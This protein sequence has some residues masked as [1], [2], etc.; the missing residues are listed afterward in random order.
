MQ[1]DRLTKVRFAVA[2]DPTKRFLRFQDS[3]PRHFSVMEHFPKKLSFQNTR[4]KNFFITSLGIVL[5][6]GAL[7]LSSVRH[8]LIDT[9]APLTQLSAQ[10][11]K[12]LD[13]F[14]KW[15]TSTRTHLK[16]IEQLKAQNTY[17]IEKIYALKATPLQNTFLNQETAI[18]E[19]FN[20]LHLPIKWHL[21]DGI[22]YALH[23]SKDYEHKHQLIGN[24]ASS[25]KGVLGTIIEKD[26]G[27]LSIRPLDHPQSRLA[28]M[29]ENEKNH[30]VFA[31][32]DRNTMKLLYSEDADHGLKEGQ[33]LVVSSKCQGMPAN[34]PVG[35]VISVLK[36]SVILKTFATLKHIETITL[37]TPKT[38]S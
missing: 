30:F 9:F 28:L 19:G 22:S 21:S 20:L 36:E 16:T 12:P 15:I 3:I 8:L 11:I 4:W 27:S 5:F 2:A 7:S 14:K 26:N 18:P 1:R 29:S 17:L 35:K 38:S 23:I 24:L 32:N 13:S 34:I 33:I 25:P 10:V 37:F 31:G 6:I